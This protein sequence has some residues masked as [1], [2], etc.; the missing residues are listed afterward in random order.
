[1]ADGSVFWDRV[2]ILRFYISP[3]ISLGL[4]VT[5]SLSPSF[6]TTI[7]QPS[8]GGVRTYVAQ[9]EFDTPP[10]SNQSHCHQSGDRRSSDRSTGQNNNLRL[11]YL[12]RC[13]LE[14]TSSYGQEHQSGTSQE[15]DTVSTKVLKV[16]F[17]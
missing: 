3:Q 11:I 12:D 7:Q 14:E 5:P 2:T 1:M 8:Y 9:Q 6:S 15:T 4:P 17:F 13:E 16:L 10:S